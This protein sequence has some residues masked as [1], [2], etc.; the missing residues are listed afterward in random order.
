MNLPG[1]FSA[2][3]VAMTLA[4]PAS[5]GEKLDLA[6]VTKTYFPAFSGKLTLTSQDG[7][8]KLTI[9]EEN[10]VLNYDV[11]MGRRPSDKFISP[12]LFQEDTEMI[13]QVGRNPEQG[14]YAYT[15]FYQGHDNTTLIKGIFFYEPSYDPADSVQNV[16]TE[17]K[18]FLQ[19][20]KDATILQFTVRGGEKPKYYNCKF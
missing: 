7:Y 19:K 6:A 16:V 11:S 20:T 14:Y 15:K 9:T 2:V 4:L 18:V 1:V 5:A 17:Q 8:C 13:E 12:L 3:F 10:N